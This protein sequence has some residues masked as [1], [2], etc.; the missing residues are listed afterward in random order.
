MVEKDPTTWGLLTWILALAMSVS[1]GVIS[2]WAKIK[3][4][5]AK[6]FNFAEMIGEIFTS[7]FVGLVVFMALVALEQPTGLAAAASGISGHMATRLLF[8]FER[9]VERKINS[10][11]E[12]NVKL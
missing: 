6:L 9:A 1:G 2:W 11:G 3:A 12:I 10:I 5:H 7:G 4:G 8:A